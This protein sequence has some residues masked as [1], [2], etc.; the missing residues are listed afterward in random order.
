MWR[1]TITESFEDMTKTGWLF[2]FANTQYFKNFLL[3]FRLVDSDTAAGK[4]H[5][6][7]ND[8]VAMGTD[9]FRVGFNHI[10]IFRPRPI[11]ASRKDP[12]AH[13]ASADGA[14]GHDG[15]DVHRS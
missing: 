9:F 11:A 1:G 10:D 5:T 4:F 3:D 14:R 13:F 15:R 8:I 7:A 12:S 2:L 6:V